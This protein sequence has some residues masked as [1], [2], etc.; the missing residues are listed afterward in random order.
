MAP[1]VDQSTSH[2]TQETQRSAFI[3][4]G[5]DE[6]QRLAGRVLADALLLGVVGDALLRVTPW[7]VNMTIWSVGIL[8]A[9][10]SL[11]RRRYET[12]PA[13]T[14]WLAAPAIALSLLFGWRDS[15]SL[16][17]FNVLA[18]LATICLVSMTL[19]GFSSASLLTSRV[20]DLAIGAF[21]T[22]LGTAFG[23]FSLLLSD[24]SLRQ[25][26]RARGAAQV[27]AVVRALLIA[28][29]LLLIFGGL[30]ASADPVF[31][32]MAADVLR[33]DPEEIASHLIITGAIAFLVGGFL[34]T[35]LLSNGP[36]A[37]PVHFP[38]GALGLTEVSV[39]LGSLV[40]LFASFVAIQLRYFFGGDALVQVTS[41]LSYAEYARRGFFE[42][43]TV[44]ALVLPVVLSASALLR[45][46]TPRAERVYRA[47]ASV[48]LVLL[49]VIMYSAFARMR[50]YQSVYGL[51]VDRLYATVF[52]GWLALVF[53]W[54]ATTV[55]RGRG[56]RFVAG[57]FFSGWGTLISLNV[58]D[59][60]GLVARGNVAR[61]ASG[62]ELDV[63]YLS[64]LGAD[65]APA[66]ASYLVSQPLTPPADWTVPAD[67]SPAASR[68]NRASTVISR[69]GFTAR[70]YAARQLLERWGPDASLDWRS[71]TIGRAVAQRVVAEHRASLRTLA[72]FG[73]PAV[74]PAQTAQPPQVA[75]CPQPPAPNASPTPVSPPVP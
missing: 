60:S 35:T 41:G 42:L 29:P 63:W 73:A 46:D 23:M 2:G 70:C 75:Q 25:V 58:A 44:S 14:R 38:D 21:R 16:A 15:A 3:A 52:M 6:R 27:I 72:S 57:V 19:T 45:R 26:T 1:A 71:W 65:A 12:L 39:A 43:V 28:I 8:A 4:D 37:L 30:F 10:F 5:A 48:L 69:D 55:L 64:S 62:K 74:Q 59:P 47:L 7:G 56:Q 61:A 31:S 67:G 9:L 11:A 66:L 20:R 68:I 51:S 50:L 53:V 33:V 36:L 40:L 22:G 13:E 54:F 24:V 32:Q 34:R 17:V 18:L 49:A